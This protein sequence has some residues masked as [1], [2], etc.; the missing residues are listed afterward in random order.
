M[1]TF[2]ILRVIAKWPEDS[3]PRNELERVPTWTTWASYMI[4]WYVV[5]SLTPFPRNYSVFEGDRVA[6]Q[7]REFISRMIFSPF[8]SLVSPNPPAEKIPGIPGYFDHETVLLMPG[9]RGS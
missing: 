7:F 5:L 4:L 2:L 8:G 1:L 9:T 3:P 6:L